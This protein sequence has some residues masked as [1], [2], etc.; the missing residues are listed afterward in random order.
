MKELQDRKK[1]VERKAGQK[2]RTEKCNFLV[3]F[4]TYLVKL[5][6]QKKRNSLLYLR[7]LLMKRISEIYLYKRE[8][9][10]IEEYARGRNH[11]LF[12]TCEIEMANLSIGFGLSMLNNIG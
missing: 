11:F 1:G 5:H 8:L 9:E 4:Y 7:F 6:I 2:K 12:I 10:T 3:S